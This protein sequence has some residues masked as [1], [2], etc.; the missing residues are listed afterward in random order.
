MR[1]MTSSQDLRALVFGA[2]MGDAPE[3]DLHGASDVH[4]GVRTLDL[5]LNEQFVAGAQVVKVIHGR[6]TGA[7][8]EGVLRLLQDHALV[9][10]VE[11]GTENAEIGGVVYVVLGKDA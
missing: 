6:G 2:Q 9:E 5:F 1:S 10:Y 3:I 7:M 4:E 11:E 8:R